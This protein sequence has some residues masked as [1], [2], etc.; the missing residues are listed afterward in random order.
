MAPS[1]RVRCLPAFCFLILL[2]WAVAVRADEE[3]GTT[4]IPP[5]LANYVSRPEPKFRWELRDKKTVAGTT[6]YTLH[7][8]SQEWQSIVWEHDLQVFQPGDVAPAATMLLWNQGGKAGDRSV[9]LGLDL[10]QRVK[11]PVALLGGIPNQPLLGG[12]TEDTLIAETYIRYLETRDETWPLLFPMVKSLVKAMDALQEFS[13]NEWKHRLSGFVVSGGSKRGW[14]TWLTAAADPRVKAIV[15]MVIDTLNMRDQMTWQLKSF[16]K[17]SDQ[18]HDYTARGLVPMPDTPEAR[19]LW[20]MVDPWVY[21]DKLTLPKL[22]IN[23]NN[24]QYWTSDALNLYWNDLKGDKWVLYVPNAGHGLEQQFADGQRPNRDRALNAL[25]A[26]TRHIIKDNPVPKLTWKHDDADG[27]ARL[28]VEA[29]PQPLA[30]RLWVARAPTRD[31]R[32]AQ[33]HEQPLPVDSE[34]GVGG[35][36]VGEVP[37]PTEGNLSFFAELDYEIDGLKH[38]LS[39]QLRIVEPAK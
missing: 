7:V 24:D 19:K 29:R 1:I 5:G 35:T 33:F 36:I 12:K 22:L 9:G 21:R 20:A 32:L 15:P 16:G 23:G 14:T 39:T 34:K 2:A 3:P 11:A 31:F 6:V 4:A 18:I 25:A 30:A 28:T 26:F 10:A 27:K 8:T 17:Y 13:K 37:L 38:Q